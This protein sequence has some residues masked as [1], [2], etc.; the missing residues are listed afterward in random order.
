[1]R[2]FSK[3]KFADYVRKTREAR[4][5]SLRQT[6]KKAGLTLARCFAIENGEARLNL[7]QLASLADAFGFSSG[8]EFLVRYEQTRLPQK[9]ARKKKATKQHEPRHMVLS[10]MANI[11]RVG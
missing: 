8:G 3:L 6:A 4:G 7:P 10:C 5:L 1:M 9:E 11:R 2:Q